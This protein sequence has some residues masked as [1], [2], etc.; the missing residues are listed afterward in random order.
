[1]PVKC[2]DCKHCKNDRLTAE[3]G[4]EYCTEGV[5]DRADED[6][7]WFHS[8]DDFNNYVTKARFCSEYEAL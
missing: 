3:A 7:G 8:I 2:I 1:M 6:Q 5:W 4:A